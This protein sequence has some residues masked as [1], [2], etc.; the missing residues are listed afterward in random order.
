MRFTFNF[1]RGIFKLLSVP[2]VIIAVTVTLGVVS[3]MFMDYQYYKF[4]NE[5]KRNNYVFNSNEKVET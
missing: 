4:K 2:L 5:N 3:V 1:D